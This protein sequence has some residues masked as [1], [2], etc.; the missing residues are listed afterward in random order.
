[1]DLL[2]P[3]N[4]QQKKAVTASD[5]PLL[6]LAGPGSG[7]TRVLTH[8]VAWLVQERQVPP[9]RVCAV[10]FTNKAAREMRTRL[11]N[12]LGHARA[13]ELTLGTF[14]ATCARILRREAETIGL[15]RDY[16]IFDADDQVTL[17][18]RLMREQN[19]DDRRFSPSA[20]HSAISRAKNELIPPESY[21]PSTYFGEIVRRIYEP[22]QQQLR[23][24]N[25][26]DFDDLLVET[27][28]LFQEHPEVAARYQE[29]YLH[30]LVDEFQDTNMAQYLLLRALTARHRNLF[31]VADEDQSIYRWRG[32]DYRN[33]ARLRQD[34]PD[35]MTCLLE[36]NYRST[37]N[38]LDTAQ[39]IIRHNR[40][41]TE[42]QLFTER[43]QGLK[44]V[45]HEAYDAEEEADWVVERIVELKAARKAR[46]GDCA[47]MYRTNA[48]SRA[49]EEAF[50]QAGLPY[51]L[52]GATRFYARRE[53]KDLIAFLRL[54]QNPSDSA[55]LVRV[56]NLPP[57]GIGAQT[58]EVLEDTARAHGVSVWQI[59]EAAAARSPHSPA[60][61]AD[62]PPL[63][64]RAIR[65]VTAFH[66]MVAGWVALHEEVTP[67]QLLERVLTDTGY[68]AYLRDGS[69]E[70]E[71]RWENVLELRA[72]AAE[73]AGATLS[74]FLA[75]VALVSDVDNLTEE[76][77]DAPTL[78]T[79]HSAKGLEFPVVFIVGLEEGLLPH[80]RSLDD[81]EALAEERRLMY[82]GV[83]R[84]KERLYLTHA[85]R[86]SR[87]GEYEPSTP[88]R[89]LENIPLE[90][91]EGDGAVVVGHR[92]LQAGSRVA[93]WDSPRAAP[94]SPPA[95]RF[96]R[97][98]SVTHPSFGPG[99]VVESHPDRNDEQVV[100]AFTRAG[101]K[102][103]LAS[104][105][106]A[107]EESDTK[108]AQRGKR[109]R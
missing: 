62:S 106:Q 87:Y 83:T 75:D 99:I 96:Q 95:P 29:R 39:A 77:V 104:Y 2:A 71:E 5:G 40:D 43:G 81:P 37:Q 6:V 57:R 109:V 45:I 58:V 98:Q 26:L 76:A 80:V 66:N 92:R 7:K 49:L 48:Q 17:V 52:V 86:R 55:S 33:I 108:G 23:A 35:L 74:D 47:V 53:I 38:I 69:Q 88:S 4:P 30:T 89:F 82:V 13:A 68:E 93:A 42:K 8:R 18:R 3:L 19:I 63:S 50:L 72:V 56:I 84:A 78:L 85:S 16:V 11:E 14:H 105:L 22:Y 28:R 46:L 102:R 27:V 65:A 51:R 36:Q 15:S 12:L 1:M 31:V 34:Y 73:Y 91:I 61:S 94:P 24:N 64:E 10:T 9:W 25:G 59:V 21:Q 101:V 54:A 90:L 60:R 20:V 79:L 97:G 32:A 107:S 70:G 103:V 67:A 41:R 44:A 100:V